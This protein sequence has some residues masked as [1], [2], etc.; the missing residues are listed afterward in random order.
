MSSIW[1]LNTSPNSVRTY[2][3]VNGGSPVKSSQL[4]Y[5]LTNLNTSGW[6][7]PIIPANFVLVNCGIMIPFPSYR[8][9]SIANWC[10]INQLRAELLTL[11]R[12][13][14]STILGSNTLSFSISIFFKT[15]M[16]SYSSTWTVKLRYLIKA[17]DP[18]F[19]AHSIISCWWRIFHFNA[20]L[21][22]S[23]ASS[24]WILRFNLILSFSYSL[25]ITIWEASSSRS[26]RYIHS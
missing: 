16:T 7:F 5:T 4:A 13:P 26:S 3:S 2:F 11:E 18:I 8:D 21:S 12:S 20:S 14:F 15:S 25:M 22:E 9:R 17:Q 1:R 10:F 23:S 19:F 6:I 24:A